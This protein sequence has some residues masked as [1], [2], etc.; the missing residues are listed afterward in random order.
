M[1][2]RAYRCESAIKPGCGVI[3]G[4]GENTV[5]IG[6]GDFIGVYSFEDNGTKELDD[7]I[8]IVLTDVPK[9]LAGATV[10]AGKRAVLKSDGSFEEVG[11][12]AGTYKTCG[13][14]LENGVKGDYLDMLIDRDTVT[15]A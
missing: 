8:G 2:R 5:K 3:Q 11:S 7:T 14:F 12:T 15:V 1:T 9:V 10:H 6:T 4:T 13:V